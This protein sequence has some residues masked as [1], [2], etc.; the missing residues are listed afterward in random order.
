MNMTDKDWLERVTTAYRAYPYPSKE[1]ER[2][3]HWIYDQYGIVEPKE[4]KNEDR[5]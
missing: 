3:I 1:I 2:F 5:I 4:D